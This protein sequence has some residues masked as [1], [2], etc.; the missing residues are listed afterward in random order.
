M[1]FSLSTYK[2]LCNKDWN[3]ITNYN[4][5][6]SPGMAIFNPSE[7][8]RIKEIYIKNLYA[9]EINMIYIVKFIQLNFIL[10]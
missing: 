2:C 9:I 10:I 5:I 6:E 3:K 4:Y 1:I 7:R 8:K